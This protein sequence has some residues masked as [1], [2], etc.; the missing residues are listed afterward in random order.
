MPQ[1]EDTGTAGR[2]FGVESNRSASKRFQHLKLDEVESTLQKVV[3]K[4]KSG[5]RYWLKNGRTTP[6]M[7]VACLCKYDYLLVRDRDDR[8][9]LFPC[10]KVLAHGERRSS[11]SSGHGPKN[12]H[13][14]LAMRH[15]R[16][17]GGAVDP[18]SFTGAS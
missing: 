8:Y 1:D 9:F 3:L 6:T 14:Q 7:S 18:A 17:D 15:I 2:D 12:P 4:D 11:A 5:R 10:P 13:L 16:L